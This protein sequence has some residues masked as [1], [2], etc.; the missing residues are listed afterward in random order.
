MDWDVCGLGCVWTGM[1]YCNLYFALTLN[2]QHQLQNRCYLIFPSQSHTL[3]KLV[4]LPVRMRI[5]SQ[6]SITYSLVCFSMSTE[7]NRD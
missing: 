5:Y 3:I 1:N 2:F 7:D 6:L 4:G